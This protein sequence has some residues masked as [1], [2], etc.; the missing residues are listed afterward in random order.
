MIRYIIHNNNF[1]Y[2]KKHYDIDN[3]YDKDAPIGFI[4]QG[5][6]GSKGHLNIDEYITLIEKTFKKEN[7]KIIYFPHRNERKELTE[8]IKGMN[9]ISYHNS[10]YPLEIELISNKIKLSCLIGTY[11]TVMFTCRL[12]YPEMP[13]YTLSDTHPDKVFQY[14]LKNQLELINVQDFYLYTSS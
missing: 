2:L 9:F 12:L 14:E 3:L 4:G 13:I 7:K 6:I 11:S 1:N 8:I 10:K 5:A